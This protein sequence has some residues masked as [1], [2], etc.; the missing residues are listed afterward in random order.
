MRIGPLEEKFHTN[1]KSDLKNSRTILKRHKFWDLSFGGKTTQI[2]KKNVPTP[3][4]LEL[5]A[6]DA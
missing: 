1:S 6:F 4:T 5:L 2:F 3:R